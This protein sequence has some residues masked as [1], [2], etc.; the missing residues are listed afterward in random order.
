MFG[1]WRRRPRI[2]EEV[3][4]DPAP[5]VKVLVCQEDLDGA[6]ARAVAQERAAARHVGARIAR[7]DA[8]AVPSPRRPGRRRPAGD[9]GP[10]LGAGD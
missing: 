8:M 2:P 5:G 3:L 7:Y 9:L 6:I 4:C 1:L 10:L